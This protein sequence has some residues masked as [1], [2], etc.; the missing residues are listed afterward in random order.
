[1]KLKTLKD[2]YIQDEDELLRRIKAE[3]IKWVKKL[4]KTPK[5]YNRDI[6]WI[7]MF[8]NITEEDLK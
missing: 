3:A 5:V 7:K 6:G 8:F 4:S 2:L 1:M